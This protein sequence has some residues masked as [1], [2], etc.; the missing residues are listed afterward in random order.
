MLLS[1][2]LHFR[3]YVRIIVIIS[4]S[5][6]FFIF[7]VYLKG[8]VCII[9][10]SLFHLVDLCRLVRWFF[11]FGFL[12]FFKKR[13]HLSVLILLVLFVLVFKS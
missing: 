7:F 12:L 4:F 11:C 10:V 13:K 8:R 6:Y 1:F 2:L 5:F 9:T 3:F